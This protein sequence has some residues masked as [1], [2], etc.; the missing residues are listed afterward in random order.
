MRET[1]QDW[2]PDRSEA[3]RRHLL[4]HSPVV[5]LLEGAVRV[6]EH[7]AEIIQGAHRQVIEDLNFYDSQSRAGRANPARLWFPFRRQ[8]W[9]FKAPNGRTRYEFCP[10]KEVTMDGHRSLGKF[11]GFALDDATG[12]PRRDT[13]VYA[14]GDATKGQRTRI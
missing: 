5:A 3:H 14:N 6:A 7:E 8:C 13:M 10:F 9:S 4:S 1:L 2:D 11:T 12:L